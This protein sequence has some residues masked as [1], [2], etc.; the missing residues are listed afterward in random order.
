[1]LFDRFDHDVMHRRFAATHA[2]LISQLVNQRFS[3]D[4][5]NADFRQQPD[6][7]FELTFVIFRN[8]NDLPSF[9]FL[10]D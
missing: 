6:D 5:V 1:M 8:Y 3:A 7:L 4:C 2:T 9:S 10:P